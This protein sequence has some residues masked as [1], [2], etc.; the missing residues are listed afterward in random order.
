M[1]PLQH[2]TIRVAW[3]DSQ[4]NGTIC[5]LPS[6]NSFCACLPRIRESKTDAEDKL[7]GRIFDSLSPAE[8]PPCKAESGFFMS[9]KPWMREFDHPYRQLKNCAETHGHLKKRSL[10]VPA[11]TAFAVPFNWMLRRN[12]KRI[13]ERLTEKLTEDEKPPFPSPWVFG[14]KRQDAILDL[15]YDGLTPEKSL[16]IFYTKEGHPLGEGIRR[17][18]VGIGLIA[19]VGKTEH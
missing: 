6:A 17:L 4:W 16:A 10:T 7:A 14:R 12:Q 18:V 13:E 19:K 2:L 8:L 15:V 5:S 9:P 3:H 11:F 1:K